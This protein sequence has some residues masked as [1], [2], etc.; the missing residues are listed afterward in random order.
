M[1]SKFNIYLHDVL[2]HTNEI[3]SFDTYEEAKKAFNEIVA[4]GPSGYDYAVELTEVIGDYDDM[5][6]YD[7]HEWM[8]EEEWAEAHPSGF[9]D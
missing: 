2:D 8:T 1:D 3:E 9:P 5:K 4:E 7:Y 6:D